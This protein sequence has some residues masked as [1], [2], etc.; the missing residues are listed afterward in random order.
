MNTLIEKIDA[1]RNMAYLTKWE[2]EHVKVMVYFD[3][4]VTG[5][6]DGYVSFSSEGVDNWEMGV[7]VD[8]GNGNYV[9]FDVRNIDDVLEDVAIVMVGEGVGK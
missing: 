8:D 1:A 7:G 2:M 6:T 4:A 3:G 5:R 9:A